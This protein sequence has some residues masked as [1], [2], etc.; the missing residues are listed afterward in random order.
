MKMILKIYTRI[1][2][3][4]LPIF[5]LPM[6]YDSFGLGKISFL[7]LTAIIGLILWLIDLWV[8]KK[9]TLKSNKWMGWLV[10]LL[11]WSLISFFRMSLGGQT[12]SLVSAFGVGGLTGLVIWFF[13]WLQVRDKEEYQKQLNFLSI[14]AIV[15]GIL[16]L[17]AFMIPTSKL[18]L[19]WPKNN[20]ILSIG[21][22][23]SVTGSLLGEA[24]L[25]LF[26]AL[27]W[28]KR[29]V[30]KLKEKTDLNG[31]FK[32]AIAVVFLGLLLLLDVYKMV[33]VGWGFLDLKT[34]W[35]IAA[36]TLK[37]NPIFGIGPG[38]FL[39]AFSRFRPASF[40]LTRL[41]GSIFSTSGVGI[42]Q[43]WTE[44]GLV[45]LVMVGLM[46]GRW[47]KSF[48]KTGF[49]QVGVLGL[50][51][52]CL[53][54]SY[55]TIFLLFWVMA[56]LSGEV[57][58]KKLI[59]HF[60]ENGFNAMPVITTLLVLAIIGISGYKMVKVVLADYYW[61]Q[62]LVATSNNDGTNTYNLQ[63]KAIGFNPSMADYRAMYS[64]TNLA[65]AQN[66]LKKDQV[67]DTDK[68]NT[69]VLVQQAVN[70][71]KAATSLDGNISAYWANL[72]SIYSSLIGMVDGTSDW[73]LQGYQQAI[74]VDP[75]N[76][77]LYMS[78]GALYYSAKD[79]VNAERAFE[80]AVTNKQDYAN[81]WYNWAY[82]AK[83]QNNLQVAVNRLQQ[84]V[85]L[86][87]TTSSDYQKANDELTT[88]KKELADATQKQQ[89]AAGQQQ[90]QQQSS[91][92]VTPTPTAS[93][94]ATLK[95][96]EVLPTVGA[97][98]DK[99]NV[100]TNNMQPAVEVTP[101][102]TDSNPTPTAGF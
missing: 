70:E 93:S 38:N 22:G 25:F 61:R 66:F 32:E 31:Y 15:V 46:I 49:W 44:L 39:E 81:A 102:I 45:G 59:L 1:V 72:A 58:E 36:E 37:N 34:S 27:E 92:T 91:S 94:D 47:L 42:L 74:S 76:P 85:S 6:I 12:R 84:A 57:K 79:Y 52:L 41:W 63:I 5:F 80:L 3:L 9:D 62:S 10:A 64:Q 100:Q 75:V 101:T 78:E 69:S 26:L 97:T 48:G 96:P 60:G 17:I 21:V 2:I 83:Q 23:W 29:L 20:P 71:A 43:I 95:A 11:V 99:I 67:S 33:K 54:I 19:L 77:T 65:L 68:Q 35:V 50:A 73:A 16:S 30:L 87:P 40:N 51:T 13:L 98:K 82:A 14:S 86:V 18:P 53:P 4:L 24:I 56:S 7:L 8:S 90:S 28:I 89:D 55:I 88:W